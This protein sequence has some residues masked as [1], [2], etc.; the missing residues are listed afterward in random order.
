MVARLLCTGAAL[1]LA[2]V[3]FFGAS[4]TPAGSLNLFGILFLTVSGVIWLA[5]PVIREGFAYWETG[6]DGAKLPLVVRFG[7]VF[8]NGIVA[9]R[10]GLRPPRRASSGEPER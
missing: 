4:P 2:A 7:P 3:A 1:L 5:W 10:K 9:N 6:G 8:I